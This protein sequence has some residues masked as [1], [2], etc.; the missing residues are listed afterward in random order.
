[1]SFVTVQY[2]LCLAVSFVTVQYEYDLFWV[3]PFI[4]VQNGLFLVKFK[5]RWWLEINAA[6]LWFYCT[7]MTISN[8][9]C[10]K[11]QGGAPRF[12]V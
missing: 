9:N 1:M 3:V 11:K 4:T 5:S 12:D 10:S 8:S 6:W 2:E 7:L